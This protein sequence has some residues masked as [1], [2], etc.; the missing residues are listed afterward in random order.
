MRV[1]RAGVKNGRL[2]VLAEITKRATGTLQGT[3]QARGTTMRFTATIGANGQIRVDQR[4][5]R[6]QR[7]ATSGIVQLSYPG[8][9]AVRPDEVRLRA[10]SGKAALKRGTTR[11][12]GGTLEVHGTVNRRARGVVRI[13]LDYVDPA[14]GAASLNFTARIAGGAWKLAEALPPAAQGGGQ[15][16]IQFTGYGPADIRGEQLAKEVRP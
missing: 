2:D 11:I 14:A 10:A 4:L 15:L 1:L 12:Q 8:N 7:G 3:F 16:S 9:D 5:G 13:R 6:S